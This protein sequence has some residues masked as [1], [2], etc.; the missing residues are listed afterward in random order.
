[1]S[2][3]WG[4]LLFF[5]A[6]VSG[7]DWMVR[8]GRSLALAI[9]VKAAPEKLCGKDYCDTV[10]E[11]ILTNATADRVRRVCVAFCS[12]DNMHL[13][14]F[15]SWNHGKYSRHILEVWFY[16]ELPVSNFSAEILYLP[17]EVPGQEIVPTV[18]NY[19]TTFL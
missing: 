5:S 6:D 3:E 19:K 10:T 12:F 4:N 16:W 9:A 7:V 14:S 1:M 17:E 8:H 13:T 2:N 15:M 18:Q 11:T